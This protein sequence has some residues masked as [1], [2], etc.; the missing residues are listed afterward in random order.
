MQVPYSSQDG[1]V[2]NTPLAAIVF[3]A[4]VTLTG[5]GEAT[6]A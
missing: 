4:A 6:P 3:L 2:N 1:P 5:C